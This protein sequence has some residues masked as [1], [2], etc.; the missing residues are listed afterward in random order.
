MTLSDLS[1]GESAR[2][3][4]VKAPQGLRQHFLDMGLIPGSEVTML[5]HAPM[6]DPLEIRVQGYTLTLRTEEAASIEVE[7]AT[8][9]EIPAAEGLGTASTHSTVGT[10]PDSTTRRGA[11]PSEEDFA[12]DLSLHDHNAHPGFGEEGKY[13]HHDEIHEL[14][15]GTPLTFALTLIF[16]LAASSFT[17]SVVRTE[18]GLSPRMRASVT[19]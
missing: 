7:A 17:V 6:G 18:V 8:A 10:T 14:P 1:I 2:I 15:K 9:P 5:G 3:R 11:E 12:Y 13:H 16:V 19:L 4:D